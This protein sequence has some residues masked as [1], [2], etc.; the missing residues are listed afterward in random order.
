VDL[1]RAIKAAREAAKMTQ[2][3]VLIGVRLRAPDW[4]ETKFTKNTLHN[5]ENGDTKKVDALVLPVLASAMGLEP[6]YFFDLIIKAYGQAPD[7]PRE[8][9]PPAAADHG[10][11]RIASVETMGAERKPRRGSRARS[12]KPSQG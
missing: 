12:P 4:W 1:G 2:E 10:E 9:A 8:A 3:D 11:A 6:S 7:E 5:W